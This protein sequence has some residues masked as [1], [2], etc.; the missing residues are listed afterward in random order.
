MQD[1]SQIQGRILI[2]MGRGFGALK[3]SLSQCPGAQAFNNTEAELGQKRSLTSTSL[4]SI[5]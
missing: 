3:M 5:E 1:P 2:F 4:A